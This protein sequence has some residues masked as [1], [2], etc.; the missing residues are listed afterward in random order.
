MRGPA[1]STWSSERSE[2]ALPLH[3]LTFSQPQVDVIARA[4]SLFVGTDVTPCRRYSVLGVIQSRQ[5][6]HG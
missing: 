5:D 2:L 6:I 4:Q 3:V 1:L